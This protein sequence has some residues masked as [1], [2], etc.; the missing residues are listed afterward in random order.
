[1][2]RKQYKYIFFYICKMKHFNNLTTIVIN[3][4]HIT[5]I[6]KKPDKYFI[7]MSNRSIEGVQVFPLGK[8]TTIHNIIEICRNKNPQDYENITNWIQGIK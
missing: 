2:K 5:E 1:M 3:K 8:I 4:L 6:V 7:Y